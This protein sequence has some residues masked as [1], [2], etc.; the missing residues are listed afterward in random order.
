MASATK[1]IDGDKENTVHDKGWC[2]DTHRDFFH[3][4]TSHCKDEFTAIDLIKIQL[5][6]SKAKR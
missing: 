2:Y 4:R 3:T 5:V 6:V 1:R